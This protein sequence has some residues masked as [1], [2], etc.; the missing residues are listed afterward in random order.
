MSDSSPHHRYLDALLTRHLRAL[1][2]DAETETVDLL[3]R[4]LRWVALS[5]GA[6]LMRQG[7]P[8]DALYLLV[9]GRL[10]TYITDDDGTTRLVREIGR[11]EVVGE[12]SLYTDAPRSATLVAIRD[13]VLARL[14]KADFARLLDASGQVSMAL[15]RQIIQRMQTE[16]QRRDVD[17]PA[18]VG[19]IAVTAGVDVA[20]HAAAIATELG[21]VGRVAVVDAARIARDAAAAD[22]RDDEAAEDADADTDEDAQRVAVQLDAIE[23]EHDFVLLIADAEATPWTRRCSRHCDELY[24]FADADAPPVLHAIEEDCLLR[25]PPRTDA[26]E[27]LVL[28]HPADR[29]SPRGTDAWLARRPVAGHLHLRRGE[30]RDVARLARHVSRTGVGLVFAGGGARGLAHLGVWRALVERGIDV[31]AVGGTSIGAVMAAYVATDRDPAGVVAGARRVFTANPT[32]D[33]TW[34]PLVSLIRGRRLAAAV[35]AAVR[36]STG[37]DARIEDLWK[38]YFCVATNY[39]RAGEHVFD[40]GPLQTAVLA[41]TAIP[42]ALPPLVVDGELLCDGGTFNNFPVDVMRRVRGVGRVVGVDLDPA[43]IRRIPH[44]DVPGPWALLR[45]RLRPRAARRYKLPSLAAYLMNVTVLFS[46]SRQRASRRLTDLYFNP[47]LARV[48][49]LEWKRFDEIVDQGYRHAC[50]VLDGAA[51]S[52]GAAGAAGAAGGVGGAAGAAAAPG[53]AAAAAA[54]A[55]A[56]P[57]AEAAR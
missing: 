34:L 39:S 32:G 40:R 33:Y 25:R 55:G 21:R 12:M 11:G 14:D 29:R 38:P 24:L 8:G 23:A 37:F 3:R 4:H 20:A 7:D 53:D 44:A 56:A 45:D 28:L 5:G 42:G 15:T 47:P 9:S 2:G 31:D 49:M 48:G 41:S 19:L 10:R 46:T 17:R 36:E 52:A 30:P 50:E 43:R 6:T 51:A 54:V 16:R 18:T 22:G 1:L 57:L 27:I 13:S 35:A 26:A